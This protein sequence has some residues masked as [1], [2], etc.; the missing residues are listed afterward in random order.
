MS[1]CGELERNLKLGLPL[2]AFGVVDLVVDDFGVAF[3]VR[4]RGFGDNEP[5]G[6]AKIRSAITDFAL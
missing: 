6:V 5:L 2:F 1:L 3:G 4:P